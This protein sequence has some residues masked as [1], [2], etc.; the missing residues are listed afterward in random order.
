MARGPLQLPGAPQAPRRRRR[1]TFRTRLYRNCGRTTHIAA[2]WPVPRQNHVGLKPIDF[3]LRLPTITADDISFAMKVMTL[4]LG[5][6][7]MNRTGNELDSSCDSWQKSVTVLPSRRAAP[8]LSA[9]IIII[10]GAII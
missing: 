3:A 5:D 6:G 7:E 10:T 1:M 9:G 4:T 2:G 8:G